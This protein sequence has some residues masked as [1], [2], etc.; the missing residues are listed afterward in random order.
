MSK[1]RS[2]IFNLSLTTSEIIVGLPDVL[3]SLTFLL[4]WIFPTLL[5][6]EM[7]VS[8]VALVIVEFINIH[9][10]AVMGSVIVGDSSRLAKGL[11]LTFLCV[12]YSIGIEALASAYGVKWLLW[13]FWLM[14][15]NRLLGILRN[16]ALSSVEQDMLSILWS[17]QFGSYLV[18]GITTAFLPVPLLGLTAEVTR[19]LNH[20]VGGH[21][22]EEPHRM[23]AWG[24]LYFVVVPFAELFIRRSFQK[25]KQ[26]PSSAELPIA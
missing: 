11:Y 21:E 19:N 15:G 13:A 4:A 12:V 25:G 14:T 20:T 3:L 22:L 7:V 2:S 18:T 9:S 26:A 23:M 24:F 1:E 6:Q 10:S 16:R 17:S 5:G 8:L